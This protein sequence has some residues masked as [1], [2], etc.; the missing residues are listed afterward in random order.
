MCELTW[1]G[2][3]FS[4]PFTL[5][6]CP[7]RNSLSSTAWTSLELSSA[8]PP[9]EA[10]SAMTVCQ[11]NQEANGIRN[12]NVNG[13]EGDWGYCVDF[14]KFCTSIIIWDGTNRLMIRNVAASIDSLKPI[15]TTDTKIK[16]I[17]WLRHHITLAT[18]NS[19]YGPMN[20]FRNPEIEDAF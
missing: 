10:K 14:D 12:V 7:D 5:W 4:F 6:S 11:S 2:G 3:R 19:V 17:K 18:T 9:I 16:L 1:T 15:Q 8:F 13:E 20:P